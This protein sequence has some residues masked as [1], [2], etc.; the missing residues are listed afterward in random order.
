MS[1][2]T[3]RPVVLI[4][5]TLSP[6]TIEALGPDFDV[7]ECDGADRGELLAAI[8]D[9]DALLVRSATKVD[10]E[11]LAAATRLKVV[12]RAGVGLDN[13]DV[14]A[15]TQ[16][17]VMV[18]NAPTSNI[19]SAAELAVALMLAAARH[20]SPA[21]AALRNGE[22]KRSKYTGIELYEKTVGIVGLGRIGVLV[23]QRLS[24]F[25][26]TVI[27]Y[28]P[29]VQ[30]GRAAQM[31]VR[32]VDLDTLLAE[33]DF[34]S[35]HLP[36]T[37]ETLGLIGDDQ[38]H[39][40]KPSL[41]LVNAARGGIVDEAALYAALKEGRVAA[42]G[43]DVFATEPCTDSPLFELDNVVATPHLGASTD[44]AQE[45][46]GIAVARSVRLALSGE[47]VPDA[48]NVQ[49][50]VIAEDVRPGIPLTEKLGRVFTALAGEVAQQI[51]VE[52][53]GEITA[54]DVKV[55]ELAALKG[56]FTDVVEDQVSYVNAPLLAAERGTAVRL[57]ADSE[58]PDH[59][60]VITIRGTLADGSQVSVSGTLVGIHQRERIVE[61]NG[62][63]VDL[64]PTDHLAFFVYEDRPGMVGTVGQI[65]GD[66]GINI[67]GMQVAR[68]EKGG[69]ALVALSVDTSIA[70]ETLEEIEHAIEAAS[71]R[72]VDLS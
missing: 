17:G 47:L 68:D 57:V 6:A 23:A 36:K 4:A 20:I 55:L 72:A 29:Y 66:A 35:V 8:V 22:W 19:V 10:S 34:M 40:V 30:A 38:L 43:L 63:D 1:K 53:R 49:G 52:V 69:H 65:L 11:A 7:R 64:E 39:R 3:A 56:V 70:A 14:R 59:R 15:A 61:V 24:A 31:G 71:V 45:K 41:V 42:A 25:G 9:A 21:H 46:A 12:A 5:E 37:P 54:Y 18:V 33:S 44:E 32:L 13:V 60:N 26:M 28:D 50:G 51:D 48:V 67:A 2:P 62:F 27:A 16:S 58:S